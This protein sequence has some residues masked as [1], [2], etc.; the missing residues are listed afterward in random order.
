MFYNS[1]PNIQN[2]AIATALLI[3]AACLHTSCGGGKGNA[4]ENFNNLANKVARSSMA[5]DFPKIPQ[6]EILR[7][8]PGSKVYME[9]QSRYAVQLRE[10]KEETDADNVQLVVLIMTPEVGK[11]ASMA[12]TYG[13]PYIRQICTNEKVAFEDITDAVAE[14][15]ASADV[16]QGPMYGNWTK[17]GAAFAANQIAPV[18]VKYAGSKSSKTYAN[19]DR[20]ATF[21]DATMENNGMDD[22]ND[23]GRGGPREKYRLHL[24]QQGLR[25]D[26]D[27][28]FPKTRQRVVFVGDARIMNPFLD[29]NYTITHLLQARFRDKE[30]VNAG[31]IMGTMEDYVSLYKEKIRYAEP[32]VLVVCTHGGDILDEYF[33]HRNRFSRSKKSYK[34]TAAEKEFYY[35]TFGKNTK[36]LPI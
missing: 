12:N 14:W 30:I 23:L 27:L 29:D 21:G 6:E 24:N 31:N 18:L 9:L 16:T 20:S 32:D 33:S 34:P 4:G 15:T 2:R 28:T 36:I 35:K 19:D 8:M 5:E 26:Y 3:A 1:Y 10:L 25:M 11:F 7:D 13:I 22:N 17:E